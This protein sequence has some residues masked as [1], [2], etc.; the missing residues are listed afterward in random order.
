M[1]SFSVIPYVVQSQS[2]Q[3]QPPN[4]KCDIEAEEV[5]T[6][7]ITPKSKRKLG[8]DD[9]CIS[10]GQAVYLYYKR[11]APFLFSRTRPPLILSRCFFVVVGEITNGSDLQAT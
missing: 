11:A 10:P 4:A 2:K 3:N 6:A 8:W 1:L 9:D 5:K 7:K